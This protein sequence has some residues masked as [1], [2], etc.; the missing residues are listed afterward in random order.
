MGQYYKIV[1]KS[2][3][4][5]RVMAV[6][7]GGKLTEFQYGDMAAVL[8][9]FS[10]KGKYQGKRMVVAG[11]YAK[12]EKGKNLYERILHNEDKGKRYAGLNGLDYDDKDYRLKWRELFESV[13]DRDKGYAVRKEFRYVLNLD[14][15][16]YIDMNNRKENDF[17][18]PV[19]ILASDPT[20]MAKGGGDYY[21]RQDFDKVGRWHN[22]R[23][24]V[25][26]EVPEG[27]TMLDVHFFE[28][29]NWQTEYTDMEIWHCHTICKLL[30]GISE[31]DYE[32]WHPFTHAVEDN[33]GLMRYYDLSRDTMLKVYRWWLS[34]GKPESIDGYFKEAA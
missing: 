14:K 19:L 22:D 10:S 9:A 1:V 21:Y 17:V 25:V 27:Y 8:H 23:L 28:P 2:E 24:S 3:K 33:G 5:N 29:E 30:E 12:A 13:Y 18:A 7:D 34:E 20:C 16:E 4:A 15:Q 26:S 11:D 32:N 31:E 6:S